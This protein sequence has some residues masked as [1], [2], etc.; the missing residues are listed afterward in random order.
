MQEIGLAVGH[1]R[2]LLD[3]FGWLGGVPNGLADH[4]AVSWARSGL[5]EVTGWPRGPG[6][7]CPVPLAAAADGAMLVF[8]A[9][10][11]LAIDALPVGASLLGQRARLRGLSR[12]GRLSPGGSCRLLPG[13]DGWIAVS[14]ARPEDFDA[15]PAW[16]GTEVAPDWAA[17]TDAVRGLSAD[18]LEARG[19]LLGLAVARA[20]G[21]GVE[22]PWCHVTGA[23]RGVAAGRRRPVVVDLSSMWAGPLAG[24][25]LQLAGADV[26][27]V[28]SVARADGA[29]M[30]HSGFF[31]WLNGG[32]RCVALDFGCEQG[33]GALRALIRQADIVIEGSRPRALRQI[34]V[35]AEEFLGD[36]PGLVWVSITAYGRDGTAGD[37][38]GF[39][40]DAAVAAGLSQ[41]MAQTFGQM[42]FAGDAIADP[43]TGLHAAVAAWTAWRQGGGLVSLSL[44]GVVARAMRLGGVPDRNEMAARAERWMRLATAWAGRAYS[45]PEASRA[46]RPLGADTEAVLHELGARC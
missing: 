19:R 21:D 26:I 14:L 32:K 8:A 20:D 36:R 17:V 22:A 7:L 46:A 40:D 15:V 27:K 23:R 29:R 31:D 37:W 34:G 4:P 2:A 35:V 5:M 11:D 3:D 30:G 10:A 44:A 9:V 38:V 45:L 39:G 24:A 6:L 1:A 28:E 18:A 13:C 12:A 42:M 43:L 16:L 25:L 41:C 33:R